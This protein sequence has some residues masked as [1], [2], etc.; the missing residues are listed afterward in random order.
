MDNFTIKVDDR[1]VWQLSL[2]FCAMMGILLQIQ[3]NIILEGLKLRFCAADLV[4]IPAFAFSLVLARKKFPKPLFVVFSI[5]AALCVVFAWAYYLSISNS[6]MVGWTTAKLF[7]VFLMLVYLI[8]GAALGVLGGEEGRRL[9]AVSYVFFAVGTI[10]ISGT[11]MFWP[12]SLSLFTMLPK[13]YRLSGLTGNPIA[14]ALVVLLAVC[15]TVAYRHTIRNLFNDAAYILILGILLAGALLSSSASIWLTM[16]LCLAIFVL[17]RDLS[18][19]HVALSAVAASLILACLSLTTKNDV[20]KEQFGTTLQKVMWLMPGTSENSEPV[21]QQDNDSTFTEK[22]MFRSIEPRKIT[23][24]AAWEAWKTAPIFGQGLGYI[25]HRQKA[26][27]TFGDHPI[28]VHNTLLWLLA[29]TGI[30]GFAVF[31]TFLLCVFYILIAS[32]SAAHILRHD[33]SSSFILAVAIFCIG[34]QV[35]SL[36]NELMF[37]RIVYFSLGMALA[38]GTTTRRETTAGSTDAESL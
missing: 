2:F 35:M 32:R 21:L 4:V 13:Q 24:K 27:K 29:E 38:V 22:A 17:S 23:N 15:L 20:L 31:I 33:N 12:E 7:G 26:E 34:W 9:F 36:A 6:M 14:F 10:V 25:M 18:F 11:N 3:P 28:Q 30:I 8:T 16:P 19:K 37:Q 5:F 1:L